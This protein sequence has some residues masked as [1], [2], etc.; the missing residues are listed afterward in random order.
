[1]DCTYNI[2][3]TLLINLQVT[4]QNISLSCLVGQRKCTQCSANFLGQIFFKK[5]EDT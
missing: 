1:M 5:I 4:L 3:V 2:K